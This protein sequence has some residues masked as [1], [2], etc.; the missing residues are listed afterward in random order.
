MSSDIIRHGRNPGSGPDR[1]SQIVIHNGV[2]MFVATPNKPY[3]PSLSAAAMMTEALEKVDARLAVMGSGR[4]D[5]L[6]VEIWLRDMRFFDE[7]NAV[8]DNWIDQDAMPVRCCQQCEMGK[9]DLKV[10]LI[11]TAVARHAP[12]A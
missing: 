9:P 1:S 6:K 8:W 5:L 4:A 11:V 2:A 3:D 12:S 7:I 10:E